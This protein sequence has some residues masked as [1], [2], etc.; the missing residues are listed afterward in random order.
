MRRAHVAAAGFALAGGSPADPG[1]VLSIAPLPDRS[2]RMFFA[3]VEPLDPSPRGRELAAVALRVLRET[4]AVTRGD[5][6]D[7]LLAAFS[8]ANSAVMAENRAVGAARGERRICIGATAIALVGREII[9][10][11]APPSQ[12]ILVQDGQVYAFPD[13]ASWRGDYTA[14][15]ALPEAQPLGFG[16]DD[17]PRLYQSEAAPG[18]IIVLCATNVGRTLGRDDEAIVSLYGGDILSSDLEGSVDHLERLVAQHDVTDAFA[19]VVT[20]S[21]LQRGRPRPWPALSRSRPAEPEPLLA[22][23]TPPIFETP[24]H[25]APAPAAAAAALARPPRFEGMRDWVI[26]LSELASAHRGREPRYDARQR[27]LAA[28]GAL[29]VRRYRESSALPPEWRAN[30]P[31]GPGVQVHSRLLAVSLVL[32]LALGGTGLAV[33]RIR[34]REAQAVVALAQVDAA[35]RST[36]DSPGTAMSAVADAEEA[37]ENARGLG[38]AGAELSRREQELAAV[39]DRVWRIER[40]S[41]VAMI[42]ALPAELG[43]GPVRLALSGQTLYL[44]AENLYE[45]DPEARLLVSLLAKGDKVGDETAGDLRHVSITDGQVVAS[46]GMANYVRDDAGRWQRQPLAIAE[47]GRLR[48][49][50]PLIAWGDASYGISGDGDLVRFEQDSTGPRAAVWA[51][52]ADT[53]DLT[54][55]RDLT[56][57]GRIHVLLEDGR[58]LTFSRGALMGSAA[59]FIM[60][61]VTDAAFLAE[62]P[63]ASV[64]YLVD[65][66]G[67]V[68]DNAGRIIQVQPSG[69]ARQ[70]LAPEP[71]P[72]DASST[73]AATS[74]AAADDVVIDEISGTVYWVANREI[75]RARIALV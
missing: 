34:D 11:Q 26:D 48:P 13:L 33:G 6:T 74:L 57:D 10:A 50:A 43:D 61:A 41:D 12:A 36:I 58:I 14:G 32:F 45:L 66:G 29:S 37:L 16:D 9:V 44:A 18:D 67:R 35:L 68:G 62:A 25:P 56:I 69:E 1:G 19:V 39:R 42:G 38:A 27:A 59:P 4:F 24:P 60:P 46:D 53:P 23:E 5:G 75:W 72:G 51:A 20:L 55:A 7:A 31:R 17:T 2:G 8:A 40:L 65:R 47:I 28:P 15:D 3:C 49:D 22:L 52:A 64:F 63:F 71:T 30:L 73:A 70:Y 21:R 54:A